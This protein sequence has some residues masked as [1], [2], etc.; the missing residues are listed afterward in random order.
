MVAAT[1]Y[2]DWSTKDATNWYG[3]TVPA[4]W[5]TGDEIYGYYLTGYGQVE[6]GTGWFSPDPLGLPAQG[7]LICYDISAGQWLAGVNTE[8]YTA[9]STGAVEGLVM[10]VVR[11][12]VKSVVEVI[13]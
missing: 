8:L 1:G 9:P 11:P 13:T 10:A 7:R 2:E 6:A 4:T 5:Q 12:I 3:P